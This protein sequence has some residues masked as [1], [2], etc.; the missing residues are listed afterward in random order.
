MLNYV[1]VVVVIVVTEKGDIILAISV[2]TAKERYSIAIA[3]KERYYYC[4]CLRWCVSGS[5]TTKHVNIGILSSV[6]RGGAGVSDNNM[7]PI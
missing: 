4:H 6:P 3:I 1:V 2:A 5:S 7:V